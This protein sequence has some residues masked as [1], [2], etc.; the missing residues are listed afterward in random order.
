MDT[1]QKLIKDYQHTD[2]FR[3]F[4]RLF[5]E[6]LQENREKLDIAKDIEIHKLQGQN[7]LLKRY[8][9]SQKPIRESKYGNKDGAYA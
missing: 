1:L 4:I 6:D 5:E 8:I 2:C 3:L 9:S 7:Q